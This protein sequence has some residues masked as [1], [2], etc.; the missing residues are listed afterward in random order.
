MLANLT[1]AQHSDGAALGIEIEAGRLHNGFTQP[2]SVLS[3][4]DQPPPAL[5]VQGR[6][7]E[8]FPQMTNFLCMTIMITT[9]LLD[10]KEFS[11]MGV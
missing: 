4:L 8:C 3:V 6:L 1:A 7:T 11:W 2:P 10:F 5:G 9:R